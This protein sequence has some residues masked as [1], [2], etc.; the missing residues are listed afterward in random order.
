MKLR[1]WLDF[2]AFIL[3]KDLC[4]KTPLSVQQYMLVRQMILEKQRWTRY[5]LCHQEE[6][7]ITG[8]IEK[9]NWNVPS[10]AKLSLN[11]VTYL[12][13]ISPLNVPQFLESFQVTHSF[14]NKSW[15]CIVLI[16]LFC[17]DPAYL[18]G[19]QSWLIWERWHC[20]KSSKYLPNHLFLPKILTSSNFNSRVMIKL[21]RFIWWRRHMVEPYYSFSLCV[22]IYVCV[23]VYTYLCIVSI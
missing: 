9:S 2:H 1:I 12:C 3:I 19:S 18:H 23:Y 8:K 20:S 4:L 15:V 21:E 6:C 22:Y 10:L 16:S 7:H 5:V 13:K 17:R 14:W 11:I